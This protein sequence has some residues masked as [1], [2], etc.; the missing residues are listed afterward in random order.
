MR[1]LLCL[2]LLLTG[3]WI[4]MQRSAE[5]RKTPLMLL[6]LANSLSVLQTEICRRRA[7]LPAALLRCAKAF[8]DLKP[9]YQ[10]LYA[11]TQTDQPFL[12]VWQYAVA[13]LRP[14][15]GE[16]RRALLA[17]GEQIGRYDA[18][19]QEAAFS[20]CIDALRTRALQI[21]AASGTSARL[22]LGCGLAGGLLLA[23]VCY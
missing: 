5:C 21:R 1:L 20:V 7:P 9:F 15:A 12:S 22:A 3:A 4:G 13:Q 11:G 18:Q 8:E 2:T 14:L 6:D 19:T 10:L 17:L 16:E 23:I